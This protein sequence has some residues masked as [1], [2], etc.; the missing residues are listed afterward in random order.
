MGPQKWLGRIINPKR[1]VLWVPYS[2][3]LPVRLSIRL[4][5]LA[6]ARVVEVGLASVA[7]GAPPS[8]TCGNPGHRISF[9]T[10]GTQKLYGF[11]LVLHESKSICLLLESSH[12]LLVDYTSPNIPNFPIF[13]TASTYRHH[14]Q[15]HQ[16]PMGHTGRQRQWTATLA[17]V[18]GFVQL[19]DLRQAGPWLSDLISR[20]GKPTNIGN[21]GNP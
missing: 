17:T 1:A 13:S 10:L 4:C 14:H 21:I 15:I 18:E 5:H 20:P 8:A 6:I 11:L 12:F 16:V 19:L 9:K 3:I 2:Y 7:H